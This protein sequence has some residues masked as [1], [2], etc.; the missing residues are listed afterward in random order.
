M[1]EKQREYKEG[2]QSS[3]VQFGNIWKPGRDLEED[4]LVL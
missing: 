2:N 4:Q 1:A 3:R